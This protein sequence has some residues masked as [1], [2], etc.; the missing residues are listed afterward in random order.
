V[1]WDKVIELVLVLIDRCMERDDEAAV[2]SRLR[3]AGIR[4]RFAV[5]GILHEQG[6]RGAELW[7]AVRAIM[8]DLQTATDDELLSLIAQAKQR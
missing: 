8:A 5:R 6:L 1:D 4:V 3:G 2:L 7:Q